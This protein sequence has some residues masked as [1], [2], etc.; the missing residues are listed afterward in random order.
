MMRLITEED[1]P[2]A[3]WFRFRIIQVELRLK[4][5]APAWASNESKP[6]AMRASRNSVILAHCLAF[7]IEMDD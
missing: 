2:V 6:D 5:S 7:K 4:P 1:S 3:L